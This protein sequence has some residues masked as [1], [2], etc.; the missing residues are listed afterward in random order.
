MVREF[1]FFFLNRYNLSSPCIMNINYLFA[2]LQWMNEET[3]V[4]FTQFYT[5]TEHGMVWQWK[6]WIK[7]MFKFYFGPTKTPREKNTYLKNV[8]RCGVCFVGEINVTSTRTS[9]RVLFCEKTH[10][11]AHARANTDTLSL[12]SPQMG[13]MCDTFILMV[14]FTIFSPSFFLSYSAATLRINFLLL[15]ISHKIEYFR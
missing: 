2:R 7:K 1:F 3:D 14:N 9:F 4:I 10:T 11:R 15:L 12:V 13:Q 6:R 8:T 5:N